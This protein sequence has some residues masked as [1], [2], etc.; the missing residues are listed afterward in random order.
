MGLADAGFRLV[1]SAGEAP[2][3]KANLVKADRSQFFSLSNT[4]SIMSLK[5][6]IDHLTSPNTRLLQG[7]QFDVAAGEITTLMGPSGC[8]KSSLL[9]AIT[10]LLPD[11]FSWQGRV[12]LNQR[13]I[14]TLPTH[15]R[16]V[17]L[18][19]QHDALFAHMNVHDN[20]LYATPAAP[21]SER[22]AS[23]RRAL[24]DVELSEAITLFPDQLSGG[25]RT[26][27][28]LMRALLARPEAL[29]LD[30]PFSALDAHL[31]ERVRARVFAMIRQARIPA[32]LVTHDPQDIASPERVLHWPKAATD[33]T[34]PHV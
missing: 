25:Q 1:Y 31:R 10:G 30:E 16:R 2:Q 15:Q 5:L 12:W 14:T 34:E 27:I 24:A 11:D 32:L 19:F 7:W 18:M 17:G 4:L 13:E 29:L 3:P 26:R 23:V 8:G 9:L 6:H 28:A 21:M 22:K 33:T 20:L